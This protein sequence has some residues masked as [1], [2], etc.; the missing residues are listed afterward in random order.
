MRGWP[1]ERSCQFADAAYTV[2]NVALLFIRIIAACLLLAGHV[3]LLTLA[4]APQCELACCRK[5]GHTS[6]HR[7]HTHSGPA[8]QGTMCGSSCGTVQLGAVPVATAGVTLRS[9]PVP[10]AVAVVVLRAVEFHSA[11]LVT[12]S[13]FQRP[14]PVSIQL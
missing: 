5:T 6:C 11:P 14:P 7:A 1:G 8:W 2:H 4:Q 13:L 10:Q 3:P 9:V 12:F